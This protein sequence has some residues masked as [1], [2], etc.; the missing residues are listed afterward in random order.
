MRKKSRPKDGGQ[1]GGP[2]ALCLH[3]R[4]RGE[5]EL[6]VR[7]DGEAGRQERFEQFAWPGV[8]EHEA[9]PEV[10]L[11]RERMAFEPL[12]HQRPLNRSI[13]DAAPDQRPI[14]QSP[15]LVFGAAGFGDASEDDHGARGGRPLD[16]L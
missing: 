13:R 4:D 3:E 16:R 7:V 12:E 9:V 1:E 10:R 5:A 14:A 2:E 8:G 11:D 6:A 15:V